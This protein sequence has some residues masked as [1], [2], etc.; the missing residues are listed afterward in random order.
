MVDGTDRFRIDVAGI[1]VDRK[2]IGYKL[3][4]TQ[5]TLGDDGTSI[6]CVA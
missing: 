5:Q 1:G 6:A 2:A 3:A 4:E